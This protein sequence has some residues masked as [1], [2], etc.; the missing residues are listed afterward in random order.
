MVKTIY[1]RKPPSP[2][3]PALP[4]T[5]QYRTYS[6]PA[7]ATQAIDGA[8]DEEEAY[9]EEAA[10]LA[11]RTAR[12][13]NAFLNAEAAALTARV[14]KQAAELD[15]LREKVKRLSSGQVR[16]SRT[17]YQACSTRGCRFLLFHA[18]ACDME[19][20]RRTVP[21]AYERPVLF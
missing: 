9:D 14:E 15:Q 3:G 21:P 12:Q 1:P 10:A 11:L 13:V 4:G 17:C 6:C 5:N 20:A 2:Q 19:C 8:Y 18:L 7:A 16:Q